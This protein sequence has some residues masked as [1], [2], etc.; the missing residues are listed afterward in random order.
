LS[1]IAVP[2]MVLMFFQLAIYFIIVAGETSSRRMIAAGMLMFV[3]T[4]M[5]LTMLLF[6]PIFSIVIFFMPRN[7]ASRTERWRDI[8]LFWTGFIAPVVILGL[9]WY[10]FLSKDLPSF[11]NPTW[12][13]WLAV[14]KFLFVARLYNVISF[15]FEHSLSSTFNL[16]SLGLWISFLGLSAGS[17]VNVD[18]Q[19]H[20]YLAASAIWFT[21]YLIV[22]LSLGYFPSRYKLHILLPMVLFIAVGVSLFQRLGIRKV[23]AF[24]AEV[25]SPSGLLWLGVLG[26]PTAVFLSPL[27]GSAVVWAGGDTERVRIKLVCVSLSLIAVVYILY[28]LKYSQQ[29]V[30]FF[31]IFPLLGG[32]AWAL[33]STAVSGYSFWPS[34]SF[35][36]HALWWSLTFLVVSA[37]SAAFVTVA[38]AS[39]SINCDRFITVYALVYLLILL[40]KIAPGYMNPHYSMRDTSRDLGLLLSDSSTIET[41][42]ADS[43]FNENNLPYK[44]FLEA[45]W[46]VERPEILVVAFRHEWVKG[47]VERDYRQI[48]TY[49]LY[50]SPEYDRTRLSPASLTSDGVLVTVYKR[51]KSNEHIVM[52][53]LW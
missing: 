6:L 4:A 11:Q 12:N 52:N 17:R 50:V 16:W 26:L 53:S 33:L 28:R 27:L 21:L 5:K 1:R 9:G 34:A 7:T 40:V 42:A 8:R 43:L 37:V 30:G 41:V 25:K 29:A 23:I 19:S 49:D 14:N 48:K 3:L 47:I 24:F 46:S 31:L 35:Q 15:P 38:N 10:F 51:R 20:R 18:F 39:G 44:N 32:M 36:F 2:E 22:M 13:P 45:N